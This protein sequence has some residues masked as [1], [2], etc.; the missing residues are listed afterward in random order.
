M[1]SRFSGFSSLVPG[2]VLALLITGIAMAIAGQTGMAGPLA[3]AFLVG[4]AFGPWL[5]GRIPAAAEGLGFASRTLLRVGVALLGFGISAGQAVALGPS[6]LTIAIAVIGI[7]LTSTIWLGTKLRVDRDAAVLIGVGTSVC[8]AS[9]IAATTAATDVRRSQVGYA[10]ATITIFGT[11]GM[12]TLPIVGRLIGLGE[13][14]TGIWIGAS[15]QEV[16]QVT[17]AGASVSASALKTATLVKLIRVALLA[18]VLVSVRILRKP[19]KPAS[20][21]GPGSAGAG[22]G[23]TTLLPPFIMAFL[24]F[25]VIRSLIP[26]PGPLLEI[27]A[28]TSVLLQTAALAAIG[29]QVN[30]TDLKAEGPRPILLGFGASLV[31]VVISLLGVVT[32]T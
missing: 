24:G 20:G 18:A 12:L 3:W 16:A 21:N 14:G 11:I 22:F 15:V 4:L 32:L 6:G 23:F 7:T 9:A 25:M 10:I 19:N 31:I 26:I 8:G 5:R 2:L 29:L 13:T 1:Q 17:A 28:T 27:S 30:L